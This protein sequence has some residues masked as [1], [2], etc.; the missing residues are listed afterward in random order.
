[1]RVVTKADG[2]QETRRATLG[3]EDRPL[4]AALLREEQWLQNRWRAL[5]TAPQGS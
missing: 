5:W 2:S 1:V 3:L 4:L